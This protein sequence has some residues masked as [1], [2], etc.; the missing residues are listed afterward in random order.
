M[1]LKS[2]KSLALTLARW[3]DSICRHL[4]SLGKFRPAR[5]YFSA[6]QMLQMNRFKGGYVCLSQE[7]GISQP[8]SVTKLVDCRQHDHQPWPIFW[9]KSNNSRLVGKMLY[10]RD[11]NDYIC[12]E[13]VFKTT[14]RTRLGKDD[15][16]A[17]TYLSKP[18]HLSGAWT[19]LVSNWGTGNNY[20]HWLTDCLCRLLVRDQ[21][22]EE[23]KILIPRS[24][25]PFVQE[26]LELLG[27]SEQCFPAPSEHVVI[28]R[29]YFCSPTAMTGVWN[30]LGYNWLRKKFT[31]YRSPSANGAPIFFTRGA[32]TSRVPSNIHKIEQTFRSYG[33][34]IIDC[35]DLSVREQIW[36]ASSAPAIAGLHGAAMTNILWAQPKT[37]I[38]E[39][40]QPDY[41]NACYEQIANQGQLK[42]NYIVE[43]GSSCIDPIENWLCTTN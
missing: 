8:E 16:F 4:P 36:I 38:L 1:C 34:E 42:Y 23:T 29:F 10:W 2:I 13:G 31:P 32:A 43:K 17:Q 12:I 15:F 3:F 37:P 30:P 24:D 25:R 9:V 19:S 35:C 33:F 40:F 5:G 22:P 14:S 20:Y 11:Q 21:L 6:E 26:T 41:L 7:P 28:E 27:I 18:Q 39:I